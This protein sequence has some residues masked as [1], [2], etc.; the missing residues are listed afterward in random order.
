MIIHNINAIYKTE[1][2]VLNVSNLNT[3]IVVT[4]VLYQVVFFITVR[5]EVKLVR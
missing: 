1:Y 2:K 4:L 3:Q 5:I